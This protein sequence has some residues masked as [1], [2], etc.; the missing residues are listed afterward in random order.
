MLLKPIYEHT[1]CNN[2]LYYGM[3]GKIC[4][5]SFLEIKTN[6]TS[7]QRNKMPE[8]TKCSFNKTYT[9]EQ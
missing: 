9:R 4:I 5:R 3:E 1:G 2:I 7:V 8:N 6:I